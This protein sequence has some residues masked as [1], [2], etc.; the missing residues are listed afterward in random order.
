MLSVEESHE[1]VIM[2]K[3]AAVVTVIEDIKAE[4]AP[5]VIKA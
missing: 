4:G 2:K 5:V 3:K 1:P